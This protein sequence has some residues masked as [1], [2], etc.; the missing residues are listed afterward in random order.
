MTTVV[1]IADHFGVV[2]ATHSRLTAVRNDR[3]SFYNGFCKLL[4]LPPPNET[5]L[6][7]H[8]GAAI[9]GTDPFPDA[10]DDFGASFTATLS[11]EE[12]SEALAHFVDGRL[13]AEQGLI[14]LVVAG[15][16][17]GQRRAVARFGDTVGL[18]DTP[19]VLWAGDFDTGARLVD[20]Y[21]ST[22]LRDNA[23]E[24]G[25][26]P[27]V[28]VELARHGHRLAA[29]WPEM[30]RETAVELARFVTTATITA[31]HLLSPADQ[32]TSGGAVQVGV[33]DRRGAGILDP[34]GWQ[35]AGLLV[36][37]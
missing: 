22:A 1:A 9:V 27:N 21:S 16:E 36:C 28:A 19:D 15:F 17:D 37:T 4:V 6:V 2:V 31:Q 20:G 24:L 13:G 32:H 3:R 29:V 7:A 12:I 10:M 23:V 33:A 30:P 18:L 14:G 5:V 25:V 26:D 8:Y 34:P 35:R 11:V